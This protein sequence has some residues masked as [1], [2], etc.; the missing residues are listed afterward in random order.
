MVGA[1]SVNVTDT[2]GDV[3][4]CDLNP[5]VDTDYHGNRNEIETDL[6]AELAQYQGWET[7]HRP[8]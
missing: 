1:S 4:L 7:E 3:I 8:G 5:V 2:R 6:A